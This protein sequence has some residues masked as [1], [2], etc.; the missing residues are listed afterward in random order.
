MDSLEQK[1]RTLKIGE[2]PPTGSEPGM[3]GR[4]LK[5]KGPSLPP[6]EL[7]LAEQDQANILKMAFK[8]EL[9]IAV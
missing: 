8:D 4:G 2:S 5:Q 7:T 1:L 9:E 6:L 3:S